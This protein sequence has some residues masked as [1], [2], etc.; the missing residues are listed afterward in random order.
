MTDRALLT[1]LTRVSKQRRTQMENMQTTKTY[2]WYNLIKKWNGLG[3]YKNS[4]RF[5]AHMRHCNLASLF[6][7]SSGQQPITQYVWHKSKLSLSPIVK[8]YVP[9][10]GASKKSSHFQQ[11]WTAWHHC[12]LRDHLKSPTMPRTW[13]KIMN[14]D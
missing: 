5:R 12:K 6:M 2:R 7:L 4:D 10:P 9:K 3:Y 1:H 11:D 14:L 13:H 8:V